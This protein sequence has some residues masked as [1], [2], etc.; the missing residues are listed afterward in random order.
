MNLQSICRFRL[1][2]QLQLLSLYHSQTIAEL[3]ELKLCPPL[4]LI[5]LDNNIIII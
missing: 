4:T 5:A 1:T 2:M 3:A